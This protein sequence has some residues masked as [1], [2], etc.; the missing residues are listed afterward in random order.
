MRSLSIVGAVAA[1]ASLCVAAAA[2]AQ[3]AQPASAPAPAA[4]PPPDVHQVETV[5]VTA[6]RQEAINTFVAQASTPNRFERQIAR[7]D[8]NICSAVLGLPE[9]HAQYMNDRLAIHAIEVGLTPGKPGCKPNILIL[10]APDAD[11][12]VAEIVKH[13]GSAF[14]KYNDV[15]GVSTRGRKALKAWVET[16][17]PV[18]WWHVSQKANSEGILASDGTLIIHRASHIRPDE[19]QVFGRVVIVVDATRA[20]GVSYQALCD[21]ISMVALAQINPRTEPAA[22][23]SILNLFFDRDA[24]R[25]LPTGLTEWDSGY[26]M[27]LY[28]S[29]PDARDAKHQNAE[30]IEEMKKAQKPK[31]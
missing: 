2:L 29:A 9:K 10:V 14:A 1:A 19:R 24:G 16:P 18:R 7:W 15:G 23:P 11:T 17:A 6:Q 30:I 22:V 3:T 26:L 25:T 21:Y 20:T 8:R 4:P 28:K 13:H 31:P 12:F 27:A 5:T